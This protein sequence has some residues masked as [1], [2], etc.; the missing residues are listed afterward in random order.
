MIER[1]NRKLTII[2]PNEERNPIIKDDQRRAKM[3]LC[4]IVRSLVSSIA[5]IC[6]IDEIRCKRNLLLFHNKRFWRVGL[7]LVDI[8]MAERWRQ[9]RGKFRLAGITRMRRRRLGT[10]VVVVV[11]YG[12]SRREPKRGS[13]LS[14]SSS[15]SPSLSSRS[16][17]RRVI[18]AYTRLSTRLARARAL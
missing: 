3:F 4:Y 15:P 10:V 5:I 14:S 7:R 17:C 16:L 2:A 8:S 12:K 6:Q 18:V 9:S 11:G 1:A 13:S